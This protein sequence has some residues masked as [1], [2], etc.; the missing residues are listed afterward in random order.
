MIVHITPPED[1]EYNL[2]YEPYIQAV[3]ETDLLTALSNGHDRFV[4]MVGS[5]PESLL[6]FRYQPEKWSL[7][8][9]L[10]HLLDVER[11]FCY[12]ALRFSRNDSTALPGFDDDDFVLNGNAGERSLESILGEYQAIRKASLEFFKNINT[13]MSLR[14]G[15]ANG[16]VFSVRALGYAIAGHEIHHLGVISSKYLAA[17]AGN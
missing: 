5:I 2:A 9:V 10:M 13:E 16:K 1:T 8:E 11:I 6:T 12:R 7:A 15:T 3:P 17:P 14:S 4:S